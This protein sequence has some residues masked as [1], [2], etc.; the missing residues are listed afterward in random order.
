VT[1][2]S[3]PPTF[4]RGFAVAFGLLWG[5]FLNVVI[6]RV[7]RG[8]SVVS[9]PS[10]CPRCEAPVR[11]WQNIPVFSWIA[12]RGKTACCGAPLSIRYPVVE[13]IGGALSL[14]LL[15]MQ[16]LA[17]SPT[18]SVG[19]A[20]A[21][22]IAWLTLGLG[23]V[24]AAFIDFEHLY[25]PDAITLGGAVLGV[26][27]ASLRQMTFVESALGAAIGFVVVWLPFIVVYEKIRGTPGM[28][29]GDAKLLALAGAWFGWPGALFALG[30]GAVQG[31]LGTALIM[32]VRGRIEEPEAVKR[33]REELL[34][35]IA[36]IEDPEERARELEE[37]RHDPLFDEA[38]E[39]WR[40]RIPFGPFLALAILELAL[41][42]RHIADVLLPG[43]SS[44]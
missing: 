41:F 12:L 26:A 13:A 23:L 44:W 11:P 6:W 19:F 40:A 18:T 38:G 16:V 27:T 17:L 31:A 7:P 3:L 43:G 24:A 35:E 25:L 28:G 32:L 22:Y 29:E 20:L 21:A 2:D 1:L 33:E 39:G 10:H 30:A 37:A 5:S 42:R 36:K 34:A 15:E 9:P 8:Q 14:G 4:L